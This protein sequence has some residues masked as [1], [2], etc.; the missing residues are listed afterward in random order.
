MC[1]IELTVLMFGR[2]KG[3][4][5][6]NPPNWRMGHNRSSSPGIDQPS[7][8]PV[9]QSSSPSLPHFRNAVSLR[10][11]YS[12]PACVSTVTRAP[13]LRMYATVSEPGWDASWRRLVTETSVRSL[14]EH[15]IANYVLRKLY[16]LYKYKFS[17]NT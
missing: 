17:R 15:T 5:L 8:P 11:H 12:P 10:N 13:R 7:N 16:P 9:I 4:Q 2:K 14:E 6:T 3:R 1:S